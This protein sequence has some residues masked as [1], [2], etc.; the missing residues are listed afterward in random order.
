MSEGIDAE[1]LAKNATPSL[2]QSQWT[3]VL[4]RHVMC[5]LYD[6]SSCE[7]VGTALYSLSDPRDL[8]ALRYIGQTR[9]PR[10]RFLQHLN[11]ARLWLP[12][13]LPWWVKKPNL[14]PLYGWIRKLYLEE[15]RLPTM[16]VGHWVSTPMGG[17]M[18]EED[19][20]QA[21]LAQKRSLLNSEVEFFNR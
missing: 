11:T 14:R 3:R 8:R 1:S 20:I 21:A 9:C 10:R 18:A 7:P 4:R 5:E 6:D 2:S 16:V 19:W 13:E 12:D 17:R 15:Q